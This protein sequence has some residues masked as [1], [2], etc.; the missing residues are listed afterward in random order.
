MSYTMQNGGLAGWRQVD[1]NGILVTRSVEIENR[2]RGSSGASEGAEMRWWEA[3]EKRDSG[4]KLVFV[5]SPLSD[6]RDTRS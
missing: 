5:S 2:E 6:F 3:W 4:D 1:E